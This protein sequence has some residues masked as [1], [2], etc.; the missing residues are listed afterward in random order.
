MECEAGEATPV[1]RLNRR[2]GVRIR[3]FRRH[4][5][6]SRPELASAVGLPASRIRDYE[7]GVRSIDA[8][9]L[10]RI[11][12]ALNVEV[13]TFFQGGEIAPECRPLLTK[14]H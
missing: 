3:T 9:D 8:A 2:L 14:H 12:C 1:E 4:A 11:G 13:G 10:W 7:A 5:G 6:L